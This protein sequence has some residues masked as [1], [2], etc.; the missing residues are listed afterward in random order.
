MWAELG[1]GI[2]IGVILYKLLS[3]LGDIEA[4]AYVHGYAQGYD[5]CDAG[6]ER[7]YKHY[8]RI[9]WLHE[10]SNDQ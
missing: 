7:A 6:K 8:D 5:D 3:G 9:K 1:L 4:E 10:R 2:S